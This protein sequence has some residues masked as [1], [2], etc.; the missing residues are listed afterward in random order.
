MKM[1]YVF[2]S[3]E[4]CGNEQSNLF[5]ISWKL[6]NDICSSSFPHIAEYAQ[7]LN[8]KECTVQNYSGVIMSVMASQIPASRLFAQPFS[9]AQSKENIKA[10]LHWPLWW[11]STGGP[12]DSRHKGPVT[13][14][15]FPFD[16]VIMK[17]QPNL[18]G[19]T[20]PDSPLFSQPMATSRPISL[21]GTPPPSLIQHKVWV[22]LKPYN[23]VHTGTEIPINCS[24]CLTG[25][26]KIDCLYCPHA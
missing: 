17:F 4:T 11:E 5:W 9:Q 18:K 19:T 15:M 13:R 20:K 1:G 6:R 21:P 14:K 26:T 16:D 25:T 23:C 3:H 10:P 7:A 24:R 12:V 22:R 8:P 2:E